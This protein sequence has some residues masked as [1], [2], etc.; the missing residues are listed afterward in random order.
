M[1]AAFFNLK[2]N[3]LDQAIELEDATYFKAYLEHFPDN[4]TDR[5]AH[6]ATL[7]HW[8]V[9]KDS[10]ARHAMFKTLIDCHLDIH[11]PDCDGE[12]PLHW[13]ASE[14]APQMAQALISLGADINAIDANSDSPLHMAAIEGHFLVA[15]ALVH[16]RADLQLVNDDDL[17]AV[18]LAT[19]NGHS[20]IAEL[21]R[22]ATLATEEH[23]LLHEAL[24]EILGDPGRLEKPQSAVSDLPM[25]PSAQLLPSSSLP[26][27]KRQTL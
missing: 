4:V 22:G 24:D 1:D 5:D 9:T 8:V 11:T 14:G 10:E 13:A 25:D 7:L 15:Q 2:Y 17:L 26:L 19:L 6:R 23:Y 27:K 12:T 18:D 20:D 16:A 3:R 21:I